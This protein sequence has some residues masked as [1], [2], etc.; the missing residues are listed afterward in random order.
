MRNS[1]KAISRVNTQNI[2]SIA[3]GLPQ[4]LLILTVLS[5]RKDASCAGQPPTFA[6]LAG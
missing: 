6:S 5:C 4:L 1:L 3:K 2:T